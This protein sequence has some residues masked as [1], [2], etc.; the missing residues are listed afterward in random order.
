M[1]LGT[2]RLA[3]RNGVCVG[4]DAAATAALRELQTQTNRFAAALGFAPL[5]LDGEIGPA[6]QAAIAL[7]LRKLDQAEGAAKAEASCPAIAANAIAGAA[8]FAA[9]ADEL[10]APPPKRSWFR[11]ELIVP[12]VIIALVVWEVFIY[13][14]HG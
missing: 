3:L 8:M 4:R 5:A 6:S 14:E 7:V 13:P 11:A 12:A 9:A 10:G 2:D 1:D